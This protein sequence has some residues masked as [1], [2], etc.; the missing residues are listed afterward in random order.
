[1]RA[2]LAPNR[3]VRVWAPLAATFLLV[4]GSTPVVNASINRLPGRVHEAELASFALLLVCMIVI[5][6]PLF[7]TREIAI[8][9]SV[10]T[11]G[12]RRAL[13]FGLFA[14]VFVSAFEVIMAL[15]P[16]GTWVLSRFTQRADL[17]AMA[18]P[19]FL[20]IAPVPFFIAIRAVY[21]AHQIRADD[22]VWV[23]LGTG[24][25][26]AL[27]AVI[28]LVLAPRTGLDGP[29]LGAW[30]VLGGIIVETVFA[31]F[32]ARHSSRPPA[33]STEVTMDPVRFGVP[34]MIANFLGVAVSLGYL[35]IAGMVPL[36][37]QKISLAAFQEVKSIHWLLGAGGFALQSLTTAK[38]RE[39]GDERWMLRFGLYVGAGLSML[40]ALVVFTPL[41]DFLLIDL[42][43]EKAGGPVMAVIT[44]ALMAAIL[45][46][47]FNAVRF[48]LRG[49]LI[50]R[51]KS[52]AIT[53]VNIVSLALVMAAI[54]FE[55]LPFG[56]NGALNAYL[57]WNIA[58]VVEIIILWRVVGNGVRPL[59]R[60]SGRGEALGCSS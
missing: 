36:D 49:T 23:G 58:N 44:P 51:G 24:V 45:M 50:S 34:L 52:R 32:R 19:A 8:K 29:T 38:V 11:D 31:F 13:R 15:T 25:R 59:P 4:T 17:V 12:S 9:L 20:L 55:V 21:Q 40:F 5:H 3:L 14:A 2:D 47:A 37:L 18:Q 28:G 33:T 46:P 26:I 22:T 7:V 6:S 41:R 42:L 56:D 60:G 30:C 16:F 54:A 43:K 53:M 39:P 10:D 48:T 57:I 1:M 35:R 27:T